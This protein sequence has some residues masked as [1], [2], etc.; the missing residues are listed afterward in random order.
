MDE[1]QN[2]GIDSLGEFLEVRCLERIL[3]V[4]AGRRFET[5]TGRET[6]GVSLALPN[7][8]IGGNNLSIV[9]NMIIS[10]KT[11][12]IEVIICDP[13]T[14]ALPVERLVLLFAREDDGRMRSSIGTNNRDI[15]VNPFENCLVHLHAEISR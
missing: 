5:Y 4:G 3:S 2:Y 6:Q 11:L 12:D 10:R 8:K 15:F 13:G 14:R 7:P 9:F 1:A